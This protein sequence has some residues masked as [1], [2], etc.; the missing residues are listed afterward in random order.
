MLPWKETCSDTEQID[1]IQR[2]RGGGVTFIE[3]CRQFG[4]SR[5]TG[6]KRL[7]R[8]QSYGWEGLGDRSRAPHHHPNRTPS[9]VAQQLITAREAHP[10]WGPK[11]L[12]AWLC[13]KEQRDTGP[14]QARQETSWNARDW[15]YGADGAGTLRHGASPLLRPTLPTTSGPLT[16]RVG[17]VP[18]TGSVLT[19]SPFRT[20]PPGTCWSAMAWSV[21]RAPRCGV[22]WS[23]PFESTVFHRS[24]APTTDLPSP[25]S[26]WAASRHWLSG[27]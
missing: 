13:A 11:K 4:V 10:T 22:S 6:Y 2:W 20:P 19:P 17:S 21:P 5:R 24:F 16:S 18:V 14:R 3:L 15:W 26:A 12:V 1:F 7:H 25:A 27:G 9:A 23:A 8:F